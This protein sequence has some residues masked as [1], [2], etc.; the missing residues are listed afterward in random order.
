VVGCPHT[1][2]KGFIDG[3]LLATPS[4]RHSKIEIDPAQSHTYGVHRLIDLVIDRVLARLNRIE[5]IAL[6]PD[7]S[8]NEIAT[9]LRCFDAV[10]LTYAGSGSQELVHQVSVLLEQPFT[11]VSLGTGDSYLAGSEIA[12]VRDEA[13]MC[14]SS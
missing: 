11:V 1:G 2:N 3:F 12:D 6:M 5:L 14:L 4:L 10:V 13:S 8:Q 9:S 7:L